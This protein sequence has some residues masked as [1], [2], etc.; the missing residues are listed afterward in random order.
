MD[1]DLEVSA[2]GTEY[3]N[4]RA[5]NYLQGILDNLP[6]GVLQEMGRPAFYAGALVGASYIKAASYTS[7][8]FK[9]KTGRLRKSIRAYK[10]TKKY[11][12]TATIRIGGRSA[13]HARLVAGRKGKRIVRRYKKLATSSDRILRTREQ[14]ADQFDTGRRT[15]ERPFIWVGLE[16]ASGPLVQEVAR[17]MMSNEASA[18]KEIRKQ[19]RREFGL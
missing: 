5:F 6:A 13:P 4:D 3:Q 1:L 16:R 10:G 19:A 9:D 7:V 8:G 2:D 12:N 11:P 18:V 17:V 14:L 15:K